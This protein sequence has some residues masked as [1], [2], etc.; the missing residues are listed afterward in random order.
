MKRF[1]LA[2]F[3]AVVLVAQP[4]PIVGKWIGTLDAG[5]QK[6]R[7]GLNVSQN[8]AGAPSATLDSIDQAAMGLPIDE[9]TLT[10]NQVRLSLKAFG[11]SYEGT[12]NEGRIEG[13]WSQGG[14]SLPLNFEPAASVPKPHRPQE[15]MP[16]FPYRSEDVTITSG[17]I[18]LAGTFTSPASGAPTPAVLLVT[19]SGPQDRNEALFDHTPFL[20]LSDH[21]TRAGIAVLRLDDRGTGSSGGNFKEAGLTEFT[22]DALAAVAWL[23]GRKEVDPKKIGIVGH[24]EGGAVGPL[25]AVQSKDIAFIVMM[26]GP[27]VPFDELMQRQTA[28][29]MRVQGAPE[30]FI[31]T[32]RKLF[33]RMVTILN[34][35]P[36]AAKA[37]QRLDAL[38]A[39]TKKDSPQLA[40][41]IESQIPRLLSPELRSLFSYDAAGMLRKVGCPV[42][43]IN[44]SKDLQVAADMNLP[45]IAAALAAGHNPDFAVVKLTGLN[46][47]FQTAKTGSIVEYG[48]IE[49][50]MSPRAL[51]LIADWVTSVTR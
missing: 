40:V 21:L 2:I 37:K 8:G 1:I 5:S 34:A 38:V 30:S 27:G 39:E 19:G 31:A 41:M 45:G 42:L 49:E 51:R 25:A 16:P 14:G 22:T 20:V 7:L 47:L 23:K 43:A 15:P 28:D 36:D 10:G 12:L 24:S 9:I 46:H 4:S 48:Q 26:A 6:L 35:E 18:T 17:A 11:A 44:G 29:L 33:D 13:N 3:S 32:N 50:T